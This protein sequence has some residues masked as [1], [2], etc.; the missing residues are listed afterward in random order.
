MT[1]TDLRESDPEQ[2]DEIAFQNH[3][4]DFDSVICG[5][6]IRWSQERDEDFYRYDLEFFMDGKWIM[7][8]WGHLYKSDARAEFRRSC[9]LVEAG[10]LP[11]LTHSLRRRR[12]LAFHLKNWGNSEK[13]RTI[14]QKMWA[15]LNMKIKEQ[16]MVNKFYNRLLSG[17]R[18]GG[19]VC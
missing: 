6:P 10:R 7:F 5:H 14:A 4:I 12:M 17:E 16:E 13:A 2:F 9:E 1:M 8:T 15:D 18:I 3:D 19:A 11:E